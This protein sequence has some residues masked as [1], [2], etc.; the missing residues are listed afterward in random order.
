MR[1]ETEDH[2][3]LQ[4]PAA[5]AA[6]DAESDDT[7]SE[8]ETVDDVYEYLSWIRVR[9]QHPRVASNTLLHRRSRVRVSFVSRV[10]VRELLLWD[11]GEWLWN[12]YGLL[13]TDYNN[14][15]DY[16][17]EHDY[18]DCVLAGVSHEN[19]DIAPL[20]SKAHLTS[21]SYIY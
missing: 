11:F 6:S 9:V 21:E 14:D 16:E 2:K 5:E 18:L 10:R 20:Q 4:A 12:T 1:R 8:A 19:F 7:D 17:F 15:D 13:Q 3:K